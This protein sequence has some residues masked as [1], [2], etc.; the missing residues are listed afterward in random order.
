MLLQRVG[1]SVSYLEV[2]LPGLLVFSLGLAITVAPLT[3][4]VLAGV[5]PS[6]AGIAS[7]V[8]NAL[9]RVAGLLATAAV[10]VAVA[11]SFSSGLSSDLAGASL[12][13]AGRSTVAQA[14]HLA[15]GV[16]DTSHLPAAE[17]RMIEQAAR[18]SSVDAFDLA[19]GIAAA[20]VA[21]GGLAGA[22]G[23]RNVKSRVHAAGCEGG[24]LVGASAEA[25]SDRAAAVLP[26]PTGPSA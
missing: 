5:D 8:N 22:I 7:A 20:M 4:A 21:A 15:L 17:A 24:A 3:A 9:A 12:G 19:M 25:V 2:L 14:Q 16:P 13:P 11:A 1:A 18:T 6:D 10:G 26:Q 23:I